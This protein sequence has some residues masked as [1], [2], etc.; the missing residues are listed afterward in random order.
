MDEH[1][2]VPIGIMI[3]IEFKTVIANVDVFSL[4]GLSV[5]HGPQLL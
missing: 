5:I 2:N 4:V 1:K 3:K